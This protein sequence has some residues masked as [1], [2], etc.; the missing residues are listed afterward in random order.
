MEIVIAVGAG[1]ILMHEFFRVILD[2]AAWKTSRFPKIRAKTI[3]VRF[4]TILTFPF[5]VLIY[6]VAAIWLTP[7]LLLS[8]PYRQHLK[9]EARAKRDLDWGADQFS[10]QLSSLAVPAFLTLPF[11]PIYAFMEFLGKKKGSS[12]ASVSKSEGA[13]SQEVGSATN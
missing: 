6:L 10:G 11:K 9:Q 7:Y 1:I 5:V 2:R 13:S 4:F 8:K 3:A 12:W